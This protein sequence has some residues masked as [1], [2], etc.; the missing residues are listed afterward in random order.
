MRNPTGHFDA[1]NRAWQRYIQVLEEH[2]DVL[3]WAKEDGRPVLR[4]LRDLATG[5]MF[6]VA[7]IDSLEAKDPHVLLTLS[8]S[9]DLAAHGPFTGGTAA[10]NYGPRLALT[11]LTVT[12][13]R[14]ALLHHPNQPTLPDDAWLGG[15]PA[16][17]ADNIRP[18]L[19][20]TNSTALV[21]LDRDRAVL[22]VVGPFRSFDAADGWRPSPDIDAGID[23][24]VVPLHSA[25]PA[26]T[27]G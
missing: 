18:A 1:G 5:D 10:S 16:D 17:L 27:V 21:L 23:R 4:T 14:T 19:A 11:D 3:T 26:T 25:P 13:T 9:T 7:I 20:T 24:L 22:T 15:L 6:T 12:H 8:G 2:F